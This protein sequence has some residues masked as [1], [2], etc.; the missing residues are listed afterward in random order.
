MA[1]HFEWDGGGGIQTVIL[2]S[3]LCSPL[4][5]R[6]RMFETE[7]EKLLLPHSV[8]HPPPDQNVALSGRHERGAGSEREPGTVFISSTCMSHARFRCQR[9]SARVV[10]SL[11]LAEQAASYSASRRASCQASY[12]F[13]VAICV[14]ARPC[15]GPSPPHR[16]SLSPAPLPVSRVVSY[17]GPSPLE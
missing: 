15:R 4:R 11:R 13:L 9:G 12:Q 1:R 2:S 5:V 6:R 10:E 3:S 14:G 17:S 16:T 7:G 8:I